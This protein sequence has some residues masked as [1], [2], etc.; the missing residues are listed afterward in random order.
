MTNPRR[1]SE[2]ARLPAPTD[3][4]AIACSNIAAGTRISH[5]EGEFVNDYTVLEGHRFAVKI[6]SQG[7]GASLLGAPVWGSD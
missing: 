5:S 7:R 1:F 4:A 2:I 3:N 6:D